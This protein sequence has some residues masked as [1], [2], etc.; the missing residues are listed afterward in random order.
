M[1]SG[2]AG[3]L[4]S[5]IGMPNFQPSEEF[6]DFNQKYFNKL[7]PWARNRL[8][9][10]VSRKTLETIEQWGYSISDPGRITPQEHSPSAL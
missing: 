9:S 4:F 6:V 1:Q 10:S 2:I 7:G 5:Q 8:M 3:R